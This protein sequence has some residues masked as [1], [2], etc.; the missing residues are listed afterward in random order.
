M[1]DVSEIT[2]LNDGNVRIT[3]L[4]AIIGLQTYAMPKITSVN[5][6]FNEPKLFLPVFLR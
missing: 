4:R 5:M 1:N 2:I 3:S 6:R